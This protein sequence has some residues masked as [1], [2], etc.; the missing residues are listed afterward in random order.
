MYKKVI[1]TILFAFILNGCS[2]RTSINSYVAK[3]S[4][5]TTE[6]QQDQDILTVIANSYSWVSSQGN[7]NDLTTPVV[8]DFLIFNTWSKII[9]IVPYFDENQK[10]V[11]AEY[12]LSCGSEYC[13][14]FYGNMRVR[15]DASPTLRLVKMLG[16]TKNQYFHWQYAMR[17]S[18]G[19]IVSLD[20]LDNSITNTGALFQR[21]KIIN[22]PDT[23]EL[24]RL[25]HDRYYLSGGL[26]SIGALHMDFWSGNMIFTG[27]LQRDKDTNNVPTRINGKFIDPNKPYTDISNMRVC[28]DAYERQ[29]YYT[30]AIKPNGTIE[31]ACWVDGWSNND[32]TAMY[33]SLAR[34]FG[35]ISFDQIMSRTTGAIFSESPWKMPCISLE[36]SEDSE[37]VIW[38]DK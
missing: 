25:V 22:N 19:L 20:P 14:S 9:G 35:A 37:F 30:G 21:L 29:L 31:H 26:T 2:H 6:K 24:T 36:C 16:T 17:L 3:P 27:V 34:L 8:R 1:I 7:P 12:F 15:K 4:K 33:I 18:D 23:T 10:I 38:I 32:G 28:Y 13:A 5:A 11:S